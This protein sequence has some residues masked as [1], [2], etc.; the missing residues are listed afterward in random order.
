MAAHQT[1]A[2]S[3]TYTPRPYD[4]FR[5][6]YTKSRSYSYG[7]SSYLDDHYQTRSVVLT[8][9]YRL[10]TTRNKY[11]GTGAGNSEKQRM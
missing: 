2:T 1:T 5:Q 8:F 4:I 11:R 9:R 6:N 7:Y 3:A 10:N